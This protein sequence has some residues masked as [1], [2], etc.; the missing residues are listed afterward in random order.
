MNIL[1]MILAANACVL[2][3][4]VVALYRPNKAVDQFGR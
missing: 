3:L 2:G 4:G 1:L